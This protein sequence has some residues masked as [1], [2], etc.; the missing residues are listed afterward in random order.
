[1][2]HLSA[3]LLC[4][5]LAAGRG[6][7]GGGRIQVINIHMGLNNN[8]DT[9]HTMDAQSFVC[10]SA[11]HSQQ[12]NNIQIRFLQPGGHKISVSTH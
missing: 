12:P 9:N 7:G 10:V 2:D 4:K 3:D 6:V 8:R 11:S 5:N 1:M